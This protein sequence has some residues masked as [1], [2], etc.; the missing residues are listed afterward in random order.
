MDKSQ[1]GGGEPSEGKIQSQMSGDDGVGRFDCDRGG[2]GL[3][4]EGSLLPGEC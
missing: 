3:R 1:A 4:A 2:T